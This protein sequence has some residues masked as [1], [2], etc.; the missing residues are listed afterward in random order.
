M[1]NISD[2]FS[3]QLTTGPRGENDKCHQSR[4]L[5][6]RP[7]TTNIV[8]KKINGEIIY[9]Y[10]TSENE[11]LD[12]SKCYQ[13]LRYKTTTTTDKIKLENLI[14]CVFNRAQIY[15]NGKVIA[16]SNNYTQDAV[17]SKRVSKSGAKN[18]AFGNLTYEDSAIPV[19]YDTDRYYESIGGLDALFLNTGRSHYIPPNSDVRFVFSADSDGFEKSIQGD[20][21]DSTALL[22]VYDLFMRVCLVH[23][24]QALP[25]NY[26][27]RLLTIDSFKTAITGQNL[28]QQF[29]IKSYL[30]KIGAAFQSTTIA[31]SKIKI[32]NANHFTY[33]DD[34]EVNGTKRLN[35]IYFKAGSEVIPAERLDVTTYGLQMAHNDFLIENHQDG[36]D[37]PETLTQY[38]NQGPV[39]C[40]RVVKNPSNIIAN[41]EL[42]ATFSGTPVASA[43]LFAVNEQVVTFIYENGIKATT[44]T[45][46]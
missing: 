43:F 3:R 42:N 16:A 39:F 44:T 19:T 1:E 22:E 26:Q 29:S 10:S 33:G 27:L 17:F 2:E 30:V 13:N 28:T 9:N 4:I 34:A 24:N 18:L 40:Y 5:Q 46:I 6:L 15:V 12:L 8:D 38:R 7:I 36:F 35:T 14:D 37:A 41:V 21:V 31:D 23:S 32:F 20:G 45:A 25:E 11:F